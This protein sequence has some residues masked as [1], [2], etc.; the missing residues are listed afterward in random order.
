M[1]EK[2][3]FTSSDPTN[4]LVPSPEFLALHATCA[5]VAYFSG[6]GAYLDELDQDVEDLGVLACDG[7][8]VDVL[9]YKPMGWS[10][11]QCQDTWFSLCSVPHYSTSR[12]LNKLCD[13]VGDL[14]AINSGSDSDSFYAGDLTARGR[15]AKEK[16]GTCANEKGQG[17]DIPHNTTSWYHCSP[18]N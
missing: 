6:A 15:K 7:R 13:R 5:K 18:S 4:L 1:P 2:I 14:T 3:T 10:M 16:S 12:L 8:S 11:Q 9:T 17:R